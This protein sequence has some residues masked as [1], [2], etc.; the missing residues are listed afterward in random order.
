MNP[1]EMRERVTV[2]IATGST[3]ALGEQVLSWSNSSAV[4]LLLAGEG[5]WSPG[6]NVV[7]RTFQL[8]TPATTSTREV[9]VLTGMNVPLCGPDPSTAS[10][11][12]W[13]NFR[14]AE[15]RLPAISRWR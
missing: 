2:Q 3:N 7:T 14:I 10:G 9:P 8:A 12:G 13:R 5:Y 15:Y 1:G 6:S 4:W 11:Q